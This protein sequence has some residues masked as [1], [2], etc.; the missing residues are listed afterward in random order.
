MMSSLARLLWGVLLVICFLRIGL[1][2]ANPYFGT[3]KPFFTDFTSFWTAAR[4]ALAG[5]VV[6]PYQLD[7]FFDA[8]VEQFGRGK[9]AFFYPPTW[10]MMMMPFGLL[11]YEAAAVVFEGITLFACVFV[12]AKLAHSRSVALAMLVFPGLLFCILHGQNSMLNV[13]LLGGMLVLLE[14]KRQILA[15]VVIG[16]MAY[17]PH[18][19]V[20][21]PIAFLAA[22]LWL[23]F[24]MAAVT[25][26]SVALL[27]VLV[28]GF[29]A[30][31]AFLEQAPL[32]QDWLLQQHIPVSKFASFFAL[33][34]SF[35]VPIWI[36]VG[37]Q[38]VLSS[39]AIGAVA[40]AWSRKGL[41][42]AI[43]GAVLVSA[44]TLMTPFILDYD[45][46]LLAIPLV[47]LYRLGREEG[48]LPLEL[49]A[50]VFASV[51]MLYSRGWGYGVDVTPIAFSSLLFFSLAIRRA[52]QMNSEVI[53]S[54][55][56]APGHLSS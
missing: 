52:V 55:K 40:W 10:L 15:G 56:A 26:V 41:G 44:A 34:M 48:F 21:V 25:A 29:D 24:V 14:Q 35:K 27:S 22:G 39:A 54:A 42:I 23:P 5:D 49:E 6:L 30:W 31:V 18:L 11:P 28:L 20:L 47:L 53:G 17:K 1:D 19:G 4:S 38:I 13:A 16:L 8:Q 45:L 50:C 2:L 36:C 37:V 32:A 7:L 3:G 43:K 12:L 46:A 33:L 9:A 51:L